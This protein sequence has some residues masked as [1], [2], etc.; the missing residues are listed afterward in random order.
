MIPTNIQGVKSTGPTEAP[1]LPSP[2]RLRPGCGAVDL[3]AAGLERRHLGRLGPN[4]G[5]I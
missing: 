5:W 2:Q 3:A 4:V 1:L